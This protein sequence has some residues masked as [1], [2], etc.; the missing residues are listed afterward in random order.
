MCVKND[1]TIY[2]RRIFIAVQT[3][4]K[5]SFIDFYQA[6]MIN[7]NVNKDHLTSRFSPFFTFLCSRMCNRSLILLLLLGQFTCGC[8]S[9]I[10]EHNYKIITFL[11]QS[12]IPVKAQWLKLPNKQQEKMK[13]LLE[14]E[15]E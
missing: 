5:K 11:L 9:S 1:G 3:Q 10:Y 15:T 13:I 4:P 2:K 6:E 14:M 7:E 12:Y 8:I